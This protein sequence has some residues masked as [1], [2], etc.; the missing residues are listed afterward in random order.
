MSKSRWFVLF[1]AGAA[2]LS[3]TQFP[4]GSTMR[5]RADCAAG[6]VQRRTDLKAWENEGGNLAPAPA[7]AVQPIVES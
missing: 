5:S 4:F 3:F 7:S 2:I 1:V 6:E